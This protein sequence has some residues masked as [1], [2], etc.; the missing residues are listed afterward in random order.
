MAKCHLCKWE[1]PYD[2]LTYGVCLYCWNR[3][4]GHRIVT[5]LPSYILCPELADLVTYQIGTDQ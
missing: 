4:V 1:T 5:P 3:I 2:D